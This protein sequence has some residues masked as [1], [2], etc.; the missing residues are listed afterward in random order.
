[1]TWLAHVLPQKRMNRL[2]IKSRIRSSASKEY[3][4][5]V[6]LTEVFA[7]GKLVL[8]FESNCLATLLGILPR[9]T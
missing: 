1:L 7:D 4:E 2:R 8:D 3:E 5:D 9:L 6:I